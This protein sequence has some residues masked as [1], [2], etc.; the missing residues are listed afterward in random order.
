M[1][2]NVK[3]TA[4]EAGQVVIPSSNNPEYGY[5]RVA[6]TKNSMEGGWL[7]S[8]EI[9]A[10]IS[11]KIDELKSMNFHK[12]QVLPG[13]IVV[14]E[15]LEPTNPNNPEQDVKT[16]GDTGIVCSVEGQ[17]IYR[18]TMYTDSLEATDT[19]IEHDNYA[20]I[21]AAYDAAQ[22]SASTADEGANL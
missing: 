15:S 17:P 13:K 5:I 4:N 2:T 19:L 18:R 1:N 16:A 14:L 21:K 7:K 3:V 20:E 6:Q 8:R 11:G 10:L 12:G 22:A 9:S